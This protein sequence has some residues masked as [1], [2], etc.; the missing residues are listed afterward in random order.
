MNCG[1]LSEMI[2]GPCL[3]VK[4][5]GPF[6]ND[7]N[8]KWSASLNSCASNLQTRKWRRLILQSSRPFQWWVLLK[9]ATVPQYC[10]AMRF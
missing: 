9:R 1:P 6:Q 3:L 5:L 10:F 2:P 4:V 7:L 8:V